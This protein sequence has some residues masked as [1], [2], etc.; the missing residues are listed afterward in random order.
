MND[1]EPISPAG[2]QLAALIRRVNGTTNR[3]LQ[4]LLKGKRE[5]LSHLSSVLEEAYKSAQGP[6]VAL[7]LS[8]LI[9]YPMAVAMFL[10]Q[11]WEIRL[12]T[13]EGVLMIIMAH[14][15]LIFCDQLEARLAIVQLSNGKR[16]KF[17]PS[18][19]VREISNSFLSRSDKV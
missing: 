3:E 9:A 5:T 10:H 2:R 18:P 13:I 7:K 11:L 14:L 19:F 17:I 8:V 16:V 4:E 12:V 1:N 6:L 15:M